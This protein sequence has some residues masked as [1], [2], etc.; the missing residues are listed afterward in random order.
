VEIILCPECGV[1]EQ[2]TKNHVWLNS[3]ALVQSNDLSTRLCFMECENLDPLYRG[4]G[5]IIG[6]PVDHMVTDIIL[7]AT[8]NYVRN[9]V[10]PEVKNMVKN[11]VLEAELLIGALSDSAQLY[12]Y[13]KYDL[14]G[15]RYEGDEDDYLT[16]RIA[17]PYSVLLCCGSLAGSIEAIV[18]APQGVAYEETSP[19]VYE[20]KAFASEYSREVHERLQLERYH[21]RDGDVELE[22][23]PTC[24]GPRA[25]SGY[26]WH[27]G[28]GVIVN[29]LDGRR[30]ALIGPG[31]LGPVFQELEKE[32]GETIPRA[33]LEMQR[34][35][36]KRGF[37]AIKEIGDEEDLRTQ[38]ALR[39]LG[40]LREMRVGPKGLHM[41]LD[42]TTGHL[43]LVGLVQGLFEKAFDVDARV[44]WS[45]SEG[46]DLEIEVTP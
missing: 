14:V 12:G 4:I 40:N 34:R 42:S 8:A 26:K 39:G 45:V 3:G 11:R 25:L 15:V 29:T 9:I 41:R 24:G 6:L 33:V 16:M 44:E 23:C 22:R 1:P 30:M 27:A 31:A 20:V 13:G 18:D 5:E 46:G 32:L 35:F 17:E 37:Y 28:R 36:A 10:P 2:F 19:G 38:L 21:H 7:K 43:M